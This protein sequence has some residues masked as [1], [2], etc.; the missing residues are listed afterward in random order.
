MD[1]KVNQVDNKLKKVDNKVEEVNKKIKDMDYKYE[2]RFT[3]IDTKLM[4][5]MKQHLNIPLEP[6]E[7]NINKDNGDSKDNKNNNGN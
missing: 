2:L 7:I 4:I 5:I 3:Q 1:N 6:E